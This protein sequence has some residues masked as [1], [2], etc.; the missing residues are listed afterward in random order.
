MPP[1]TVPGI[2]VKNSNPP[3]LFSDANSDNFLSLVA[4]PAT[5]V[6]FGNNEIFEKFFPN[7][8]IVPLNLPSFIKILDPAPNRNIFSLVPNF[9]KKKLIHLNYQV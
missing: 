7:L 3:R 8:I 1:P 6:L 9:F 2:Q 5:I 4:L